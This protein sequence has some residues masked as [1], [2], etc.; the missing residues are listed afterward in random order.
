MSLVSN[1][2]WSVAFSPDGRL[3]ASCDVDGT[4][5]VW[6][7]ATGREWLRLVH[8]VDLPS[9]PLAAARTCAVVWGVIAL[10]GWRPITNRGERGTPSGR[11]RRA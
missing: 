6:D 9:W 5:R 3:A 4:A 2:V 10:K 1:T 8:R 11:V 7:A